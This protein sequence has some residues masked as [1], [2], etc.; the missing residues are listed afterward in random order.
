MLHHRNPTLMISSNS[1]DLPKGPPPNTATLRIRVS[2]YEFGGHR[3]SVSKRTPCSKFRTN[4]R[5]LH[6]ST[7]FLSGR[8]VSKWYLPYICWSCT[9]LSSPTSSCPLCACMMYVL[10]TRK[11]QPWI[12]GFHHPELLIRRSAI[13]FINKVY[14]LL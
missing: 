9:S 13:H 14:T 10:C 6:G 2:T 7:H 3:H 4:S 5:P 1:T 12:S 8:D 11:K